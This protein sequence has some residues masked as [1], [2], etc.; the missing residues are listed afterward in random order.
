MDKKAVRC[1][2]VGYDNQQKGWKCCDPTI[3]KCYTSWNV[4]FDESSS[5]W[6]LEK[7]ILPD[8]NVFKDELQSAQIQLSLG[9]A[10]D[11]TDSDIRDDET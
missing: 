8:S 6:S 10:E 7:E 5:W 1:V 3:G 11:A 4:V 9:E 2:F